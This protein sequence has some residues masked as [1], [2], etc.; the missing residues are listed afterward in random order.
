MNKARIIRTSTL[1]ALAALVAAGVSC[2]SGK[3]ATG[4]GPESA[5]SAPVKVFKVRTE[6]IAEKLSYTGTLEAAREVTI[7]PEIAGKIARIYV[8]E[9]DRVAAGDVLAELDTEST[10][11]QL[12]QAEAALAA[13]EANFKDAR[14][15]M[16]RM[17]KLFEENAVSATQHEKVQ[18]A[19]EAA[20]A[21]LA[22]ARAAVDLAQH[23]LDVSIMKAP[24][25]G[26][27]SARNAKVG[28][29]I[30]PMMGSFSPTSGV[31]KLVDYS[32]VKAVV[33]VT[34]SDVARIRKG[35]EAILR[36]G[37][38]PGRDFP[39]RVTVVNLAADPASKKFRV[40]AVFENPELLLRPGTFGDVIFE[41]RT[42]DDAL[43]VPQAALVEGGFVYVVEG[44]RAARRQV[45]L[46]LR[47]T[48]TVE[49]T[50]GLREGELV[51]VEGQVGLE[52]GA[53][54]IVKEE[55]T[56]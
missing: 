37:V 27:I 14:K 16:E 51:V 52:D 18:L 41:V 15:N 22:Q 10:R 24:F 1:V 9:G 44:G 49:V 5:G 45:A 42:K 34:Q 39:G 55:V 6:R 29:V 53:P 7:T 36:T 4:S 19:F 8:D 31:L 56:R 3:Q 47:N 11:L 28:D 43:V 13:A 35:Q 2:S 48:N 40:E 23:A 20:S 33:A 26:I 46:G 54:V 21:Q 17:D 32:R 25:S 38:Y 30:N 12:K 50:G